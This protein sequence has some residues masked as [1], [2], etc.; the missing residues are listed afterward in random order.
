MV[1]RGCQDVRD[2]LHSSCAGGPTI[3]IVD[4]GGVS[5]QWESAEHFSPLDYIPTHRAEAKTAGGRELVLPIICDRDVRGRLG[6]CGNLFR[7]LPEHSRIIHHDETH[8]GYASGVG[9]DPWV[10]GVPVVLG[11]GDIGPVGDVCGGNGGINGG[12]GGGG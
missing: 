4:V 10:K 6:G 8:Y 11:T 3:Q 9:E 12:D 7:P 2:F 1:G 5:T